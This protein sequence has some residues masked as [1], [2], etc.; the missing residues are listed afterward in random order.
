VSSQLGRGKAARLADKRMP[1]SNLRER[2]GGSDHRFANHGSHSHETDSPERGSSGFVGGRALNQ[3]LDAAHG[4]RMRESLVARYW[5]WSF[6]LGGAQQLRGDGAPERSRL[7]R[8][9]SRWRQ[10]RLEAAPRGGRGE[11]LEVGKIPK[12]VTD[13]EVVNLAPRGRL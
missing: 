5:W 13:L 4:R 1:P 12:K 11:A 3:S 9:S 2:G 6:D 7:Q 8:V 10:Q